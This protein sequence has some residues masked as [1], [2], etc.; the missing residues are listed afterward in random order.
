M[1]QERQ[2]PTLIVMAA[3]MGSRYGG[4]KQIEP[5][6]PH[7]E[8]IIDYSVY[9]A[10]QA[11]F[12]RVLFVVR[13]EVEEVLRQRFD[14][15][16]SGR[17]DVAYAL[18][19]RDD[20]P[21]GFALPGDR[22]KPW[23]TGQ[24]VLACRHELDS[25]F[26]VVNADDFYGPGGYAQLVQFLF[27]PGED[28][29]VIGYRLSQ[30]MTEHGTVSRGVCVVNDAGFL[31]RIDERKRV[32]F[33]DEEIAFTEDGETWIPIPDDAVASMNMWGFRASF[34]DELETRFRTFLAANPGPRDEFSVP[35]VIGE[36][37]RSGEAD[38]KVLP[39]GDTWLGVTYKE[40]LQRTR[41]G[42]AALVREGQYPAP[43]WG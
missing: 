29:A 6:G 33:R 4:P 2:G 38:V 10:I 42:I 27:E 19:R 41:D 26:A 8:W 31:T 5:V 13:E 24:A 20:L 37:L 30:T 22:V 3:G 34:V 16:L 15:A 39:T 36:M 14:E 43:L 40:D 23:G 9:D 35:I 18:Q 1:T 25:P 28:H 11:G 7:G 12:G 32:G 21:E 17:C